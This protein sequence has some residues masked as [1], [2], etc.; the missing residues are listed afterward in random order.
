MFFPQFIP[1]DSAS[2]GSSGELSRSCLDLLVPP[3]PVLDNSLARDKVMLVHRGTLARRKNK[4]GKINIKTTDTVKDDRTLP[5]VNDAL[6]IADCD[7]MV[8]Q[9]VDHCS[10]SDFQEELQK[11]I[12]NGIS[13][14]KS[15][16][17]AGT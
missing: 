11:K 17:V 14:I 5:S 9:Q 6:A 2:L 12:L 3:T 4:K 13:V 1:D 8:T 15:T 7:T 16:E 10:S